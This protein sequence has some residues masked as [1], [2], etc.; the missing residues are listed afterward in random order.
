MTLSRR[1]L[2]F[3]R[4]T[5]ALALISLSAIS[6]WS[7]QAA[8]NQAA[9][10]AS[11]KAD[12]GAVEAP[13]YQAG[14]QAIYEAWRNAMQS[15]DFAAWKAA[16]AAYRQSEIRN[17]I[18]S[19]KL[20][21]PTAMFSVPVTA[22]QLAQ[23]NLVNIF[24][25]G[26]TA[27]AIY[28]GKLDFGAGPAAAATAPD[29]FLV[30]RYAGEGD[31]WKFDN[32]RVIKFGGDS[33]LLLKMR[34]GDFSFLQ[35]PEF[36]PTGTVPPVAEKVSTPDYLAELWVSAIGYEAT[37]KIND[38][39]ESKVV[40]NTGKDLVIGGIKKGDN[41]IS[42]TVKPDPK[43]DPATPKL[44]EVAIYSAA[45]S[46]QPAERIFHHRVLPDAIKPT[47]FETIK[48]E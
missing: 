22:P 2:V 35:D 25:K 19:Q 15:K 39:H 42:I 33:D 32:M 11:E 13:E 24:I 6:A 27:T 43:A 8:P 30:L 10:E 31:A 9:S 16:T 3:T 18:I 47:H 4:P 23:L 28:F 37:V 7:Q 21:F 26:P 14:F 5:L 44:L 1:F 34:R 36:Q 46:N 38:Q 40:N 29:S 41:S 45:E 17:R 12:P 48:V 20:S